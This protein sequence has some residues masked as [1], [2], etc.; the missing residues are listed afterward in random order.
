[1][2]D[3]QPVCLKK[4]FDDFKKEVTYILSSVK[5][6]VASMKKINEELKT[7]ISKNLKDTFKIAQITKKAVDKHTDFLEST[8]ECFENCED[9]FL[10]VLVAIRQNEYLQANYPAQ[11]G[12]PEM[13]VTGPHPSKIKKK[14]K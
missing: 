14:E 2:T 5:T 12:Y 9:T 1:M 4:E 10:N 11:K 7:D 3:E 6:V 8:K 13:K